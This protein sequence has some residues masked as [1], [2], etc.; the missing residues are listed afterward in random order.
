MVQ[1]GGMPQSIMSEAERASLLTARVRLM[2]LPPERIV[3]AQT[4]PTAPLKNLFDALDGDAQTMRAGVLAFIKAVNE[5]CDGV[6]RKEGRV[7]V[8]AVEAAEHGFDALA[9]RLA[10]SLTDPVAS[11]RALRDARAAA[12]QLDVAAIDD[13]VRARATARQTKDFETADRLHRELR[14]QGVVVVDD[15]DGSDWTLSADEAVR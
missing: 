3:H 10:L 9:D 8:S 1:E 5:L 4:A 6:L 7:N 13:A 14:A 12:R 11:L 15:A 2:K